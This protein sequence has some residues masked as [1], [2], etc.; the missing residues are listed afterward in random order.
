ML[1]GGLG[2]SA[3]EAGLAFL[4]LAVV[5]A[6]TSILG[7]RL[8]TRLGGLAITVGSP[9]IAAGLIVMSVELHVERGDITVAW[10]LPINAILGLGEGLAVLA[11]IGSVLANV[12]PSE[13]GS[14]S[15]VLTTAQNFA[16]AAGVGILG[17]VFFAFLRSGA[18]LEAYTASTEKINVIAL[19]CLLIT[20][21]LAALIGR[22]EP[23]AA[24]PERKKISG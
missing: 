5:F 7:R 10:L 22:P 11:L 23:V 21:G 1:Q 9:V 18:D 24:S 17:S 6:A 4:P 2:L 13:A 16:S 12:V 15:G 20:A 3:Q 19:V 8:V 14:A